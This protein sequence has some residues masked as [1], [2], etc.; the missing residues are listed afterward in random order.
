ML[1]C[2]FGIKFKVFLNLLEQ[3]RLYFQFHICTVAYTQLQYAWKKCGGGE[4]KHRQLG[5][6]Q[7]MFRQIFRKKIH[8]FKRYPS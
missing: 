2:I 1:T 7:F 6:G 4:N 3:P 5:D 8:Q